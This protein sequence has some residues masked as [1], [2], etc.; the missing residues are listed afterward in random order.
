MT[1][2][3]AVRRYASILAALAGLLV[4]SPAIAQPAAQPGGQAGIAAPTQPPTSI[5]E[6]IALWDAAL[7][8]ISARLSGPTIEQTA[9]DDI[10]QE[11]TALRGRIDAYVAEHAPQ[12]PLIEAR[13]A[14]LGAAP[15]G[16]EPPEPQAVA[17]QRAELRRTLGDLTGALKAAR[18]ALLR[19][20][21]LADRARDIRRDLF[22]HRVLER[23]RSPLSPTLWREIAADAPA[24]LA[25]VRQMVTVWWQVLPDRALFV[26]LIAAAFTLWAVLSLAAWRGVQR[27]RDWSEPETAPSAWRRAASAGRVTLLRSLPTA[28]ACTFLYI[29]LDETGLLAGTGKQLVE[30]AIAGIVI[31]VSVQAVT[32]TTLAISRPRWRLLKLSDAPARKLYFRVMVLAAAFGLDFFISTLAQT[33]GMP[34]SVSVGQSFISSMLFA[35]LIVS[36]LLI[37]E[38]AAEPGS[39]PRPIGPAIVRLVLWLVALAILGAALIGY[40]SLARFIAGQLVVTSTVVIIAYLLIV[41]VS[42]LSESIADDATVP[43]AWMKA[44][45]GLDEK[46]RERIALPPTLILKAAIIIAAA[47]FI[48]LLWG[49]DWHDIGAWLRQALFGFD[50]GGMRVS[51]A[52]ILAALTLFFLGYVAAKI[53]QAWLD[54][55]VLEHAGIDHALR[56]SIRTGVGYLGVALAAIFAISYAG[57]DFSNL[58]IVAGALSVGVGFGLQSVINNFVSGLILLAERPIKVGDWIIVGGHEGIVRRI[59]VRSTEIETFDRA[60]VIVP[61]SMLISDMV[62]NWTLHNDTGRMPVAVSVHFDSDPEEVRDILLEMADAHP[63]VLSNPAPFVFFESFGTSSLDFVLYVYLANIN[64]S[65]SVRTDLRIAIL[66]AFRAKGVTIPYPQADIHLRDLDWVKAALKERMAPPPAGPAKP[67]SVRDYPSES[68]APGEG[69]GD[70]NGSAH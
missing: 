70:G 50:I 25:R 5:S 60:N 19:A 67:M 8:A 36:I 3:R 32:K 23:G 49:F 10:R 48:L 53:F 59:S 55:N 17:E 65:F 47:P 39:P 15:A 12:V 46:R 58:A 44:N 6:P 63:Q 57:L 30:A 1:G 54:A 28:I 4:A 42:A 33:A 26:T 43:G 27:Y 22:G 52:A 61:N 21:T 51:I 68:Q 45:L 62:K 38:P 7:T 69:D 40:V 16:A 37:K 34:F 56:H 20:E 31:I 11:L 18:E 41:W 14:S 13:L 2:A 35:G 9:L 64:R 24:A 29:C 66:K